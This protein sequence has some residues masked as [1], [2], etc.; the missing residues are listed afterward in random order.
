MNVSA[1]NVCAFVGR[2]LFD[3]LL[4][5]AR[6]FVN[7]LTKLTFGSDLFQLIYFE[8]AI[9]LLGRKNAPTQC[10]S[11]PNTHYLNKTDAFQESTRSVK[12]GRFLPVEKNRVFHGF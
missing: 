5:C 3:F 10:V 8:S 1:K 11:Q 6:A 7:L 9:K 12:R 4:R 2:W